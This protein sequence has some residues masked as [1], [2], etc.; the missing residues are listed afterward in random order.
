WRTRCNSS[1]NAAA[2]PSGTVMTRTPPLCG[3][4]PSP[5]ARSAAPMSSTCFAKQVEGIR[6]A[7]RARGEGGG[8]QS[9]GVRVITVPEGGA[10]ALAEELQ[11]VLQDMRPGNRV[12]VIVPGAGGESGKKPVPPAKGG[13]DPKKEPAKKEASVT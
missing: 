9:G 5:S 11:R 2:P 1:A 3:P 8:P 13:A 6:A 10:A 7:L 12:R 4:P